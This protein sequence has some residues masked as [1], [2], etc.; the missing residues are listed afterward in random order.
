MNLFYWNTDFSVVMNLFANTMVLTGLVMV[1]TYCV[2][3]IGTVY[4]LWRK[5]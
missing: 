2:C 3:L 1:V 4:S 5:A